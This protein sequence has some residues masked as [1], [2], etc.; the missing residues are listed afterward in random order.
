MIV[1]V[2]SRGGVVIRHGRI[3]LNGLQ[4]TNED[5]ASTAQAFERKE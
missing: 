3:G 1:Y 2:Q 5:H 4:V